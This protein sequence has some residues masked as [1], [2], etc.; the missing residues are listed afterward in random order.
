VYRQKA[1]EEF[2]TAF[3]TVTTDENDSWLLNVHSR[4]NVSYLAQVKPQDNCNGPFSQ[5][6]DVLVRVKVGMFHPNHAKPCTGPYVVR[7]HIWPRKPGDE[8]ILRRTNR[9][10]PLDTST[11]NSDNVYELH[12]PSCDGTYRVIWHRQDDENIKGWRTFAY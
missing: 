3:K 5:P 4:R 8:V 2:F 10:H 11:V 6:V 9:K 7:G 1:N 12:V